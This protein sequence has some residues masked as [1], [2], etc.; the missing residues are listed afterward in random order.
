MNPFNLTGKRI[1]VTGASSG[2]GRACAARAAE[3]GASVVLTGRRESALNDTLAQMPDADRHDV[4]AGDI[5]DPSFVRTLLDQVAK[6]D[7][8]VHAAGVCPA[9]PIGVADTAAIV[10]S[11][12]VNYFAFMELMKLC[13]RRKYANDGFSAVAISSVSSEVG[14][15]GGALHV[16]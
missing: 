16:A 10:D 4:V 8:L 15:S 6:I 3:L 7:G 14:W 5:G 1:L 12:R 13:S 9:I 11:M 2:I